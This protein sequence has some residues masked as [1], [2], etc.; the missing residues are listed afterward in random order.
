MKN[1]PNKIWERKLPPF[2]GLVLVAAL[3]VTITWLTRNVVLF[4]TQAATGAEPKKVQVTNISDTSFTVTYQTDDLMLG[5][6]GYGTNDSLGNIGLDDRDQAINHTTEHKMHHITIKNLTPGSKYIFEIAS[7]GTRYKNNDAFYEVTTAPALSAQTNKPPIVKGQVT[8]DDGAI[9]IEGIVQVS[10][11]TSQI[12]TAL[13]GPDGSY[14]IPLV[15]LRSIDLAN[16]AS[17][18]GST[19]LNIVVSDPTQQSTAVVLADQANPAPLMTLSKNYDFSIASDASGSAEAS[20]SATTQPIDL[21]VPV[22]TAQVSSP[23]IITPKKDQAFNDPQPIFA[24]KALPNTEVSITIQSK[25][26]LEAIVQSDANGNWEF[27]PTLPLVPGKYIMMIKS[28]DAQGT[29]QSPTQT[30]TVF[31]EGSQFIEPSISPPFLPTPMPAS[32]S[33][34]LPTP[35]V[36]LAPSPT[37]A[38]APTSTGISPAPSYGPNDP[39]DPN[40]PNNWTNPNSPYYRGNNTTNPPVPNSG[41]TEWIF[42]FM[43]ILITAG[44]GTL[45]FFF[46]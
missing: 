42:G 22:D 29:L 21:P 27:R 41:N 24:G 39:N 34:S 30:F 28:V 7:G 19:K 12:F 14:E 5:S 36:T 44:V 3:L 9:P 37:N 4:G 45:L 40:N 6:V 26:I 2:S 17:I 15:S 8:L 11:D 46:I 38:P 33:A 32:P 1:I 16:W 25:E 13:L 35:T 31:A 23:T 18:N 43:G 20:G 10:T